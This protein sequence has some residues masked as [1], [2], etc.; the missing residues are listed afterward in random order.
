LVLLIGQELG[1]QEL[2]FIG[3]LA[4]IIFGPRKIPELGRKAGKL[5]AEFRRATSEFKETWES[6]VSTITKDFKEEL[7]DADND[8][9]ML[10]FLEDPKPVENSISR[11]SSP[12][13]LD[14]AGVAIENGHSTNGNQIEL[15]TIKQVE[16]PQ[17]DAAEETAPVEP[18]RETKKDWL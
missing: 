14:A 2:I 3:I 10:S 1:W 18:A 11:N 15:P 17:I 16:P 13:D 8:M 6:E 12:E 9:R 7:K 4:L 5:M